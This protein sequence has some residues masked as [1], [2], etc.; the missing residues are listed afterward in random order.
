MSDQS[1]KEF[2]KVTSD[3]NKIRES[4]NFVPDTSTKEGYEASK[5]F[6]LDITTPART[7]L[8]NAHK[9][10]KAYWIAGGKKVD[11]IK[12]DLM[13][14]LEEIQKPHKLAYK[15]V[16]RIK[17]EKKEKFESDLQ[18]KIDFFHGF[19]SVISGTSD[20]I[21]SI[22][23]SCGEV[24]TTEGF[25]HRAAD[26]SIARTDALQH[27]NEL[28]VSV[29]KLEAEKE[30][31]DALAEENRLRQID[32]DAQ[33]EVMRKHQE[34][35]DSKQA[36]INLKENE[37]AK[38]IQDE[39]A[40]EK[41]LVHEKELREQEAKRINEKYKAD[42][43]HKNNMAE[44]KVKQEKEQKE[45]AERLQ[46]ERIEREAKLR[47]GRTKNRNE[48][49]KVLVSEVG[50]SKEDAVKIMNL[51]ASGKVPFVVTNF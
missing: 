13:E 34:K 41:S 14:S 23:Q 6:V 42:E 30:R 35:L 9:L 2:D 48:A 28:L 47:A 24:D 7:K 45:E 8:T 31:Q 18:D 29:V 32:I 49:A 38:K 4:G 11:G 26:A 51:Q 43:L 12:N 16:D 17:K 21:T 50:I 44:L 25:Y 5:R 19:K 3:I 40:L 36:E 15:E 22:I 20:Q 1:L 39:M 10:V 33:L 46:K 27:L 37:A